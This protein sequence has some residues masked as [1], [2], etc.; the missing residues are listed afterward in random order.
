MGQA[1]VVSVN[2]S[3]TRGV[4]KRQVAE[5]RLKEG[6]GLVD[7][8]HSGSARQVSLLAIESIEKMRRK[9]LDVH[10]G[11]FAENITTQGID[12]LALPIEIVLSVGASAVLRIT[13]K[14]KV[15]HH[16]CDI[17]HQAGDC[18]MPREGIFAEVLTGG[19]IAAG[20]PIRVIEE[21]R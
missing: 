16:R 5:G 11:D 19:R 21:E 18:V 3:D 13:E 6:V 10:P 15:C 9:G 17:Y 4:R 1:K 7:D 12:L 2:I 8:A 20:D 14:G